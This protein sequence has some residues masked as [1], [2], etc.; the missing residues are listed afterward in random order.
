[1]PERKSEVK[2]FK[3]EYLCDECGKAK[4]IVSTDIPFPFDLTLICFE[5]GKLI[6]TKGKVYLYDIKAI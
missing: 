1:M 5:C 6:I 3:T 2:T 4:N